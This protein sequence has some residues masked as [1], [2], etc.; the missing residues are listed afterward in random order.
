[1][2]HRTRH[3]G[4]LINGCAILVAPLAIAWSDHATLAW[5]L[6]R[7]M[8]ETTVQESVLVETLPEFLAAESESVAALLEQHELWAQSAL[9]HYL[10]R[11]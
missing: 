1:M 4:W 9:P 8:P 7:I 2:T 10:M 3:I 11:R 5:P 6:L